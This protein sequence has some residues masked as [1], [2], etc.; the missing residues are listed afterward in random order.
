MYRNSLRESERPRSRDFLLSGRRREGGVR[1]RQMIGRE[2]EK[3]KILLLFILTE[4]N[5]RCEE[6]VEGVCSDRQ[7]FSLDA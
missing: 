6:E 1:R 2:E 7:R 4:L 5:R 3:R